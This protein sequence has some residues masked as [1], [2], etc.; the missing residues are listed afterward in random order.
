MKLTALCVRFV[1]A[2]FMI[3]GVRGPRAGLRAGSTL[4]TKEF[5]SVTRPGEDTNSLINAG[6]EG[7]DGKRVSR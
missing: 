2:N 6:S 4:L 1:A 7:V 5:G 3:N